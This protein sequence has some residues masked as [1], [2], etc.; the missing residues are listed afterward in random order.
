MHRGAAVTTISC[1]NGQ[2]H[3]IDE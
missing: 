2:F 1:L 3:T